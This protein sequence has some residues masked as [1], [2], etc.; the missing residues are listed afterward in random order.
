MYFINV[1]HKL[2]GV[3]LNV[4]R[5]KTGNLKVQCGKFRPKNKP[6]ERKKVDEILRFLCA[7]CCSSPSSGEREGD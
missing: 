2:L 4:K 1:G 3:T 6:M 5:R 7:G